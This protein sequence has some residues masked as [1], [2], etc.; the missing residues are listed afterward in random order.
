MYNNAFVAGGGHLSRMQACCRS[1]QRP[2][3]SQHTFI[4]CRYH[5]GSRLKTPLRSTAAQIHLSCNRP[6]V[7]S[8]EYARLIPRHHIVNG[9]QI[10]APP[11]GTHHAYKA[12]AFSICCGRTT[13]LQYGNFYP[14]RQ[15]QSHRSGLFA[16]PNSHKPSQ[17]TT[18][19]HTT[20]GNCH[21]QQDHRPQTTTHLTT[22]HHTS[23]HHTPIL[24]LSASRSPT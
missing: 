4:V 14:C 23:P 15:L 22:P 9:R 24:L 7:D 8:R 19:S 18:A 13:R 16:R 10:A 17:Q 11:A 12:T 6:F 5:P 20:R 2:S 21:S 1:R 3:G